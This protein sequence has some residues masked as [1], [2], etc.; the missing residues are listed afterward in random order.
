MKLKRI[1]AQGKM[2]MD[3]DERF[4]PDGQYPY[5]ENIRVTDTD[6][7]NLGA[8]QNVKGN[9]KLTDLGLTNAVTIGAFADAKN[10]KIFMDTQ[11]AKILNNQNSGA[12]LYHYRLTHGLC[13]YQRQK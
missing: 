11:K 4:I 7:G 8:L 12:A 6:D 2:N 3:I 13:I 5:A 1:F 9:K 10:Q